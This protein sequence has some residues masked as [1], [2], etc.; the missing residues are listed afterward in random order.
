MVGNL[1]HNEEET[2]EATSVEEITKMMAMANKEQRVVIDEISNLLCKNDGRANV[3]KAYFIDGPGSTG[4]TF[5]Y[6]CLIQNFMN[7]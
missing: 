3:C 2:T 4:K 5:V 7:L 6:R 1:P